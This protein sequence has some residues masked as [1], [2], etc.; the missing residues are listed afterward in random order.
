MKK[1]IYL[2]IFYA[3]LVNPLFG[4]QL[5]NGQR[6]AD[7][8]IEGQTKDSLFMQNSGKKQD[9]KLHILTTAS[10]LFDSQRTIYDYQ[11]N[12]PKP[13]KHVLQPKDEFTYISLN[14]FPTDYKPSWSDIDNIYILEPGDQI[15]CKISASEYYEFSGKGADKLNC[16]SA[17]YQESFKAKPHSQQ[18]KELFKQKNYEIYYL[19]RRKTADSVLQLQLKIV[20]SN[21]SKIGKKM[22]DILYANCY[23]LRY[24]NQLREQIAFMDSLRFNAFKTGEYKNIDFKINRKLSDEALVAAPVYANAILYKLILDNVL[25]DNKQIRPLKSKEVINGVYND[26]I[27]SYNGLL[28][29]KLLNLYFFIFKDSQYISDHFA[30]AVKYFN[31]KNFKDTFLELRH[32]KSKGTPFYQFELEDDKGK[33][34]KR[35]DLDKNIVILDFW[36][37]G[38][39]GCIINHKAMKP[40]YKKYKNDARVKFVSISIDKNKEN[41]KHSI[42]SGLYTDSNH[43]NLYTGGIGSQHPV[44]EKNQISS[45]PALYLLKN[46]KIFS[47]TLPSPGPVGP[48]LDLKTAALIELIDEA[49]KEVS[50]SSK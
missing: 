50:I 19:L 9:M 26:I 31:R 40:I 1:I 27:K 39:S 3:L 13:F 8:V 7:I 41:W 14:V 38:C 17:I 35:S 32:V 28:R 24:F 18:E 48:E 30:G 22:T 45:Y 33:M 11:I 25:D 34:V 10:A 49:L 4:Q 46:G 42:N 44:I 12:A 43:I 21:S 37:S 6:L 15:N 20:D 23:G 29:E 47:S 36:F 5:H 2:T 16:Q